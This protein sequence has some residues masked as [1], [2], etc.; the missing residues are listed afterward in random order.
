MFIK[1]S[2]YDKK[3]GGD[4]G[5]FENKLRDNV[6]EKFALKQWAKL[7][8]SMLDNDPSKRPTAADAKKTVDDIC[9][10]LHRVQK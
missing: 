1:D 2:G 3:K 4:A 10:I 7:V 6:G 5:Y 8:A 9:E